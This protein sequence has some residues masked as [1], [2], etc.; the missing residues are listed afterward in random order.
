MKH[1]FYNKIGQEVGEYDDGIRTYTSVRSLR[2]GEI[3]VRKHW[4]GGKFIDIPI[5]IDLTILNKLIE[6][7]CKYINIIIIGLKEHSYIVSFV[8][9][10]VKENGI[11]INFG[12]GNSTVGT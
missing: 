7:G 12:C 1:R 5:A 4:F 9:K 2:K 10:W 11:V 3:F 6:I 8:P